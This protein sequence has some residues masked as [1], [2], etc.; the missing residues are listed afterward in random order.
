MEAYSSRTS[1]EGQTDP[2]QPAAGDRCLVFAPEPVYGLSSLACKWGWFTHQGP[3]QGLQMVEPII[4]LAALVVMGF[5]IYLPWRDWRRLPDGKAAGKPQDAAGYGKRSAADAGVHHHD[6]QT[7]SSSCS[8]SAIFVPIF[9][10]NACG[11]MRG[12]R[13][14][15]QENSSIWRTLSALLLPACNTRTERPTAAKRP[16]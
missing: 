11:P 4:T 14:R 7:A 2:A 8:S 9:A 5:L 15:S 16:S 10:L 13:V 12:G 1:D 6:A 3:S